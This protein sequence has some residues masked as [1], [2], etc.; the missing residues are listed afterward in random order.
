MPRRK[1]AVLDEKIQLHAFKIVRSKWP[2][3]FPVRCRSEEVW[4]KQK[5]RCSVS[6]DM[7]ARLP[8]WRS[9]FSLSSIYNG[10]KEAY[11]SLS[12]RLLGEWPTRFGHSP[13]SFFFRSVITAMFCEK[14]KE[15]K[16]ERC[17]NKRWHFEMPVGA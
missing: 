7:A 1:I 15:K 2:S 9:P 16:K 8:S 10:T 4:A 13:I 3:K 12:R 5:I 6:M 17:T 14:K 11:A